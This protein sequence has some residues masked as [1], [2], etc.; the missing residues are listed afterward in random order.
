MPV[1]VA[2][3][4]PNAPYVFLPLPGSTGGESADDCLYSLA[5]T[6]TSLE[7]TAVRQRLLEL[8]RAEANAATDPAA[9]A[10]SA[11]V[12]A[13][14]ESG[15]F[16]L[17]YKL[18][19]TVIQTDLFSS[20][21][22]S[23]ALSQQRER[24]RLQRL[25]EMDLP[26][27]MSQQQQM[28]AWD[29]ALAAAAGAGAGG[30]EEDQLTGRLEGVSLCL[31]PVRDIFTVRAHPLA[32][33]AFL[34]QT[35]GAPLKVYLCR[36]GRA[37]AVS[38]I[39]LDP[40]MQAT[41]QQQHRP[42]E[43]TAAASASMGA[44][45]EMR[46]CFPFQPLPLPGMPP[47]SDAFAARERRL[48]TEVGSLLLQCSF[49]LA[50]RGRAVDVLARSLPLQRSQWSAAPSADQ[51]QQTQ[52]Q[53]ATGSDMGMGMN[54]GMSMDPMRMSQG[55]SF[56]YATDFQSQQQ[57]Q[58][59]NGAG[60]MV[61][62]VA[63]LYPPGMAAAATGQLM[64]S[65]R[66]YAEAAAAAA[67]GQG[68]GVAGDGEGEEEGESLV[69][70]GLL[71]MHPFRVTL[72]KVSLVA[73]CAGPVRVA[74]S[75]QG[76][77]NVA[78]ITPGGA[79]EDADADERRYGDGD[80]D[81]GEEDGMGQRIQQVHEC[82][83]T[84]LHASRL[85]APE[86]EQ[87]A[88]EGGLGDVFSSAGPFSL[89]GEID[90]SVV[91]HVPA[92]YIPTDAPTSAEDDASG[93]GDG[94]GGELGALSLPPGARELTPFGKV[95]V[96]LKIFGPNGV[97]SASGFVSARSLVQLALAS[98]RPVTGTAPVRS[99][100]SLP[101]F[102]WQRV[103]D[104]A[105]G[106]AEGEGKEGDDGDIPVAR[107]SK[108]LVP[109]GSV[110]VDIQ[111]EAKAPATTSAA[112]SASASGASFARQAEDEASKRALSGVAAATTSPAAAS[113]TAAAVPTVVIGSDA[114]TKPSAD[115]FYLYPSGRLVHKWKLAT[116]VRSVSQVDVDTIQEMVAT[117]VATVE[118]DAGSP[119]VGSILRSNGAVH[120]A[121][122]AQVPSLYVRY[123]YSPL[124]TAVASD[125][126][127]LGPDSASASAHSGPMTL[128]VPPVR[129]TPPVAVAKGTERLVTSAFTSLSFQLSER[130]LAH[131]VTEKPLTI[132]VWLADATSSGQSRDMRLGYAIVSMRDLNP[133]LST[134]THPAL[135]S[136][137]SAA[138]ASLSFSCPLTGRAFS[139]ITA[140]ARYAAMARDEATAAA[141]L[142]PG[143]G[144][145]AE[146]EQRLLR[147]QTGLPDAF[148]L[149]SQLHRQAVGSSISSG[150]PGSAPALPLPPHV[151]R[152]LLA[153]SRPM[154]ARSL[155]L[156]VPVFAVAPTL[157][158]SAAF[159]PT[160]APEG[161]NP[162][163]IASIRV[164]LRL[165][166]QG[167]VPR[168]EAY[169]PLP[170]D[171][172]LSRAAFRAAV[173]ATSKCLPV[174]ENAADDHE[175][176]DEDEEKAGAGSNEP[177]N[178][179]MTASMLP[180][181]S[182]SGVQLMALPSHPVATAASSSGTQP[183]TSGGP[184]G[185]GMTLGSA[186][187]GLMG[188]ILDEHVADQL[189]SL[190]PALRTALAARIK[191]LTDKEE[192]ALA[193]WRADADRLWAEKKRTAEEA[194]RKDAEAALSQRAATLER[195]WT[196]REVERQSALAAAQESCAKVE[197]RLRRLVAQAEA[198]EKEAERVHDAAARAGEARQ[199]ELNAV[200][201][202]LKEDADH[203]Q[204]LARQREAAAAARIAE[205]QE[206]LAQLR[207]RY[208]AVF[209]E[210]E[211]AKLKLA[212]GPD[213]T[214]RDTLAAAAAENKHLADQLEAA[215]RDAAE[216]QRQLE[217]S[218]IQSIRLA[219]EV[220]RLRGEAKDRETRE[221]ERL[222]VAWLAREERYVLE[223]DRAALRELRR[224]VEQVK[225][226]A[227]VPVSS[228][229]SGA[230]ATTGHFG[231]FSDTSPGLSRV[232]QAPR[233]DPN[234]TVGTQRSDWGASQ[235][236]FGAAE[237]AELERLRTER[238]AAVAAAGDSSLVR[239]L[240]RRMAGLD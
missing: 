74:V 85:N 55:T 62:P 97:V 31:A 56:A 225:M 105:N 219:R 89:S 29:S 32:M 181:Q 137:S 37:L 43:I 153:L 216:Q 166:D 4:D 115:A 134:Q 113:A 102:A 119:G 81:E 49:L 20:Y 91:L 23:T 145:S 38:E 213:A 96:A 5:V 186:S 51:M 77:L 114:G 191:A 35:A 73:P 235:G 200:A 222:R 203:V 201:K 232:F 90:Q 133:L 93:S 71:Y 148:L 101:L 160:V 84:S 15:P 163:S 179:T 128:S 183:A 175:M 127:L 195:A 2:N 24:R 131:T 111:A 40:L 72:G 141:G 162:H 150:G 139:S 205:S 130:S 229:P 198:K 174:D 12:G 11:P 185:L 18:F 161:S 33:A 156:T 8:E 212:S 138:Q 59:Y 211:G 25:Q 129:S 3:A 180:Y 208:S 64:P 80:D 50:P 45:S 1:A 68:F 149:L 120:N 143:A 19:G 66:D 63:L 6:V 194:W 117:A 83:P 103:A 217:A 92:G 39:S 238:R 132:E 110:E 79:V 54:M 147:T 58:Q 192:T 52:G 118:A 88:G 126:S 140:Y 48:Q 218:R 165:E 169:Q 214:L 67:T 204:Q 144:L 87:A 164:L 17:S 28:A 123:A 13:E 60:G 41:A 95:H 107:Q 151:R 69:Q 16:W 172:Y 221:A 199:Q 82:E 125:C 159:A 190:N 171:A 202:R 231:D 86:G 223:G 196:D 184:L 157:S 154:V 152:Q 26:A 236:G 168:G 224:Q 146:A 193:A 187:N 10:G 155:E 21:F 135:D 34:A 227:G 215:R 220:A 176:N 178:A 57:Q 106:T 112:P 122:T 109:V 42:V 116:D 30:M 230:A 70:A 75:Y 124:A 104:D 76:T 7:L 170:L 207:S 108:Q 46:G 36:Q 228:P 136:A 197:A 173:L 53:G 47:L 65:S 210:L 98:K 61:Q 142:P 233:V 22:G 99:R 121:V 158:P 78:A 188:S 240:D 9:A 94:R 44:G 27:S 234:V 100:V 182:Q 189:L 14:S 239:D 206:E 177:G 167:F 226:Q 209:S 237:L